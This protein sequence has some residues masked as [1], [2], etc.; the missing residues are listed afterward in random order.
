VGFAAGLLELLGETHAKDLTLETVLGSALVKV[1][2]IQNRV[3]WHV[4][5]DFSRTP[6]LLLAIYRPGSTESKAV[7]TRSKAARP[8]QQ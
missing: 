5:L 3:P 8:E 4:R 7:R 1:M 2:E 6:S